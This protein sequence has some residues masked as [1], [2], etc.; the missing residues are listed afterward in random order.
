[1][2][3]VSWAVATDHAERLRREGDSA[4]REFRGLL[5]DTYDDLRRIGGRIRKRPSPDRG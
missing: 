4:Y 5:G 2:V 3:S 1:V